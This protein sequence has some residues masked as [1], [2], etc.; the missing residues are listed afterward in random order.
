MSDGKINSL[1][2]GAHFL[3]RVFTHLCPKTHE[4]RFLRIFESLILVLLQTQDEKLHLF[5][6]FRSNTNFQFKLE[7]KLYLLVFPNY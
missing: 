1:T 5:S 3:A 7:E 2:T 6:N 4:Y